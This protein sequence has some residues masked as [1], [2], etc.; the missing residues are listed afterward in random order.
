VSFFASKTLAGHLL[1]GATAVAFVA[2]AFETNVSAPIVAF[3]AALGALVALRG[4]P[5]C[6]TLGLIETLAHTRNG[7]RNL[8]RENE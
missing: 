2:I 3:L 5:M 1:R 7:R 8:G 6:W 4:C